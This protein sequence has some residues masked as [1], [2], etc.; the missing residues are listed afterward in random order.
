MVQL[1]VGGHTY[2]VVTSATDEELQRLA[3]VVEQKL[4]AVV[5]SG[6]A[7]PPHAMLLA[8]LALAHDLEEERARSSALAERA[9][10]AFGRILQR[11]DAAL[12]STAAGDGSPSESG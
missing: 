10:G 2:R 9:R 12:G 6:K 11:V 5:P 1:R 4:T 3:A 7:V 8:A